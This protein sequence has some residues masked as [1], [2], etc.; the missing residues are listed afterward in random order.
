[1]LCYD[2]GSSGGHFVCGKNIT[3]VLF[4]LRNLLNFAWWWPPAELFPVIPVSV[5][6]TSFQGLIRCQKV[7]LKLVFLSKF[8]LILLSSTFVWL[9]H[10][11]T[12][13]CAECFALADYLCVFKRD[14]WVAFCLNAGFVLET[15]KGY[16]GFIM[17]TTD[18]MSFTVYFIWGMWNHFVPMAWSVNKGVGQ[19]CSVWCYAGLICWCAEI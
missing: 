10:T 1:M 7:K 13:L 2:Q 19:L 9:W 4:L 14:D 12:R 11:G 5:N 17:C 15:I 3:I 16:S 8:W 18:G 6:L